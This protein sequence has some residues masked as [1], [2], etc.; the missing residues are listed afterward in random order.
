GAD[1]LF[2][3]NLCSLGAG[4]TP[5]QF[6]KDIFFVERFEE[7][8]PRCVEEEIEMR[9]FAAAGTFGTRQEQRDNAEFFVSSSL[10]DGDLQ[11]LFL[12]R[13]QATGAQEDNASF[14]LI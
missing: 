1:T 5:E 8:E 10:V 7:L 11:L 12:P 2:I 3:R 4:D 14:A 6:P 9:H 13:S